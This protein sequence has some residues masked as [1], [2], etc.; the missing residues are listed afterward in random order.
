MTYELTIDERDQTLATLTAEQ[1]DFVHNRLVRGRRT[2]FARQ[3]AQ[4]K[5]Q[6]IPEDAE[7]EDIQ[8][9]IEEWDYIG[10]TDSGEVTPLTKCECGRSL[11]YQHQVRH[12]PTNTI[13]YFGIEHLQLHTG[14]DAKAITQILK[15]FDVLDA[16]MNEVLHKV[17]SGWRL[18][19]HMFLPLPD[20][21]EVPQDIQEQIDAGLPLL[22]RQLTRLRGRLRELDQAS[23]ER[24]IAAAISIQE[25][26]R[27]ERQSGSEVSA[28]GTLDNSADRLF[29]AS[30]A[31]TGDA[32]SN[33]LQQ[34]G[35]RTSNSGRGGIPFEEDAADSGQGAFSF[36]EDADSGQAALSFG[37]EDFAQTA[38]SF[39]SDDSGQAA[40]VF[41]SG[42]DSQGAFLFD[43]LPPETAKP[44]ARNSGKDGERPAA[45][46]TTTDLSSV[47]RTEAS[48]GNLYAPTRN[49]PF[50]LPPASQKVV[51]D[52][53]VYG[54]VSTLALSEFLIKQKL[55]QDVRMITK[56]PEIYIA[57]AA[58]LDKLTA[59]GKCELVS[60][61]AEDR[62]YTG[63]GF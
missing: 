10:F 22:N 13:R 63:K 32:N 42:E 30:A 43:E 14:I 37:E 34:R 4:K 59:S 40:F 50:Y 23:R 33:D 5:C 7:F 56:K 45:G 16:E 61:D 2:L 27:H 57:V 38:F 8:S 15:G 47:I 46:Q 3:L 17:R 20:A 24:R 41:D 62:V 39:D 11:R 31:D 35:G 29:H 1:R 36:G 58:F 28:A 55:V 21:L 53:L 48:A 49:S 6:F 19:E 9:F 18:D 52:A 54:R 12:V 44:S 25:R 51:A 60:A 26:N